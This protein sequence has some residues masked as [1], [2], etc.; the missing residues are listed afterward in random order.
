MDRFNR[1]I[2]SLLLAVPL[3]I[4]ATASAADTSD[5]ASLRDYFGFEALEVIRIGRHAGPAIVADIN[6]DGL[7]DLVIVNNHASRIEIHYQKADASPDDEL[8]P[9]ARVNDFPE[10]WRYQRENLSVTHRI[11]GLVA[12]DFNNDGRLDLIY[13]GQPGEIVFLQQTPQGRFQVSRR[14]RVR[15]LA[16]TRNALAVADLIGDANKE[17]ISL[18]DGEIHIWPLEED[19]LSQPLRLTAGANIV[20]FAIEDFNGDGRLDIAGMIPE[21]VAPVRMWFGSASGSETIVGPQHRFEMPA[22]RRMTPV[23]LPGHEAARLAVIEQASNRIL[24]H[25]IDNTELEQSG[26]RAAAYDVHSYTDPGSRKRDLVVIDINGDGLLDVLTT[27]MQA[28]AVALYSQQRGRGLL[29]PTPHASLSELDYIDARRTNDGE[30]ELFVLSER[31]G[32]VGRSR[33]NATSSS[34][35]IAFPQPLRVKE[36][37]T[38]IAM[39]LVDL[40]NQPHIAIIARENRDHII[41]LI[42]LNNSDRQTI[43]LGSQG[44]SPETIVA[45]DADQ[46]GSTDLLLFTRDRPMMMLHATDEGFQLL[47][48]RDMGQFGLVQAA[49]AQ[50]T[51][52]FDIDGDG[53]DELLLAD[54]NYIRALRYNPNPPEG[55]SPGWQVVKQINAN[56]RS[57]QLV[58]VTLLNDRIVAADRANERLLII[59]ADHANNWRETESL[60]ITGFSFDAIHAGSFTGDGR[61]NILAVGTDG[62]AVIRLAGQHITLRETAAWR[63]TDERQFHH[64]L[65]VGDINNDGFADLIALDAGEQMADIF[66]FTETGQMQYAT[67]FQIYE[68]RIFTG[69]QAREFQPNQII[70]ADITGDGTNDLIMIAHDRVLIYPQSAAEQR[71]MGMR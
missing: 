54:R 37:Y 2:Y 70:I 64:E 29:A 10:H 30:V 21:D 4:A 50:N 60:S 53:H 41:E 62:F 20:S 38:P 1:P 48:S 12:H 3:T 47:E 9:P 5:D 34:I 56:E 22:L 46:D 51:T 33:I 15:N 36:G 7:N 28:N 65:G 45:L 17:L 59:E 11:T 18:V 43:D 66:T 67:G 19:N 71:A 44:R 24:V 31:E 26:N 55:V 40:Q 25:A 35:D 58:A 52:T 23:A 68:S 13:S 69:G 14:H 63:S 32:V 39:S 8:T 57:A 61:E 16:S 27:D 49:R 42:N 6:G